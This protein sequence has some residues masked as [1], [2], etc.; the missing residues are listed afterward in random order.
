M[1][2]C[3]MTAYPIQ[4]E[5]LIQAVSLLTEFDIDTWSTFVCEPLTILTPP[6][7]WSR[8]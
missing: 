1:E 7:C 4:R 8:R 3:K 2:V 5:K 6:R